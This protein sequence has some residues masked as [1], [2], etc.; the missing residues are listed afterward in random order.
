[1]G[2]N[3]QAK[4]SKFIPGQFGNFPK[5]QRRVNNSINSLVDFGWSPCK[6]YSFFWGLWIFFLMLLQAGLT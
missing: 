6:V 3:S 5:F 4:P 1:M 2:S